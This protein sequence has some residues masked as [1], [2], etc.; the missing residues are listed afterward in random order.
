MS[1]ESAV[2]CSGSSAG[3]EMTRFYHA[4]L[5]RAKPSE[6]SRPAVPAKPCAEALHVFQVSV[7]AVVRQK[8]QVPLQNM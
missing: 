8:P 1:I 7:E 2:P 3:S 4:G 6:S 5:A